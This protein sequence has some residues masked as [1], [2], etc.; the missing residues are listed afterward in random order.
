HSIQIRT[1]RVLWADLDHCMPDEA[2][3]RC[4]SASL[5]EPSIVVRSGAGVH[6]YWLLDEPFLIDDVG[7]PPPVEWDAERRKKY[8]I[9]QA[10][11]KRVYNFHRYLSPKALPNRDEIVTM[12]AKYEFLKLV[13]QCRDKV[14][15]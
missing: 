14:K 10:T 15:A 13:R 12:V 2:L 4:R 6:L 9:D 5:P 8:F 11:G 7:E 1:V 3:E